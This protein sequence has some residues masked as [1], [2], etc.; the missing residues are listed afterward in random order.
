MPLRHNLRYTLVEDWLQVNMIKDKA[1]RPVFLQIHEKNVMRFNMLQ[2][3][4][5]NAHEFSFATAEQ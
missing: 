4:I 3:N 1:L 5:R 2:S